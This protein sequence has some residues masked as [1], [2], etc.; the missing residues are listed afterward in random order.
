MIF[1]YCRTSLL[2]SPI[3]F[4]IYIYYFLIKDFG[5]SKKARVSFIILSSLILCFVSLFLV[6]IITKGAILKPL[7]LLIDAL[8]NGESIDS[9]EWIWNNTYY[10]INQNLPLS[11][12]FGRGFGLMN[13]MLLPINIANWFGGLSFPTHNGYLNLFAEG[14]F[15]CLFAYLALLGYATYIAIKSFKKNSSTTLAIMLG[16]LSFVFY[17]LIETIHYLTYVFMFVLFALYNIVS[18]QCESN[19]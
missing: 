5:T 14:G 16:L 12:I 17:S 8:K 3:L 7:Y 4:L 2:I 11:L 19:S 1:T 10:L 9:R 18:K 13:E 6:V 15:I